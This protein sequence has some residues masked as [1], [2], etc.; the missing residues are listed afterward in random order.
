DADLPQ[1]VRIGPDHDAT[2]ALAGQEADAAL[3]REPLAGTD[4]VVDGGIRVDAAQ[5]PGRLA[6]LEQ[7]EVQGAVEQPG[8]A[9]AFLVDDPQE[10][11]RLGS[12]H[13]VASNQDLGERADG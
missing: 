8:E 7:A 6:A 3:E 4:G 13:V 1:P 2:G 12:P 9:H 10:A 11:L 5:L